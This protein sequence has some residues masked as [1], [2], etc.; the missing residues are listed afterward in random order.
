[1]PLPHGRIEPTST[2]LRIVIEREVAFGLEEIWN[3]FT[4]PEGL[5]PW[6][7]VLRGNRE[8]GDLRF[9]MVEEGKEAEPASLEILRCRAPHELAFTTNSEYGAWQLGLELSRQ[10]EVS[11]IRFIQELGLTDDPSTIGPGWEYYV[12]RAII[13]LEGG[14]ADSVKWDDFYPALASAYTK[15]SE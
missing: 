9:S 7:G 14:D 15:T 4:T 11:T 13:S 2:G 5:E 12:Q 8:A 10:D 3:A 6:V 1:M